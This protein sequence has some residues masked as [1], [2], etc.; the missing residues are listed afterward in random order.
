MRQSVSSW[1]GSMMGSVLVAGP[2]LVTRN[3]QLGSRVRL[4]YRLR[5]LTYPNV[6]F[7]DYTDNSTGKSLFSERP[8]TFRRV[9]PDTWC[10]PIRGPSLG[11]FSRS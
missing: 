2:V 10:W 3:I 5:S 7:I 11:T 8:A 6:N 4:T 1:S 9:R